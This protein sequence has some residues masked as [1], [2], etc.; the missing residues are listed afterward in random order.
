MLK[1]PIAFLRVP[2]MVAQLRS[3]TQ[4]WWEESVTRTPT[5]DLQGARELLSEAAARKL[6]EALAK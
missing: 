4:A 6:S 3:E 5:L 1:Q 2:S